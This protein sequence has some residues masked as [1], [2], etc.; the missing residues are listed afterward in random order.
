V[1]WARADQTHFWQDGD[2]APP[3]HEPRFDFEQI[4]TLVRTIDEHNAA[5]RDW[6]AAYD[7]K[8]HLV[9]YED[10]GADSAG[11]TLGIL[12]FLG[13]HL[14]ADRAIVPGTRGQ[15]DELNDD[16]IARPAP[17]RAVENT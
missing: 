2:T 13:L 12:D 14:S 8:S 4:H 16:W 7:V 5:C 11:V 15:A 10:L 6:F 1:S 17:W 3:G 9:R